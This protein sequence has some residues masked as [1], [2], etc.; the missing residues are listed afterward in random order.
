M[1]VPECAASYLGVLVA[2]AYLD[3]GRHAFPLVGC[4][5][6]LQDLRVMWWVHPRT[7]LPTLLMPACMEG[8]C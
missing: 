4:L 1:V 3:P 5:Q 6:V 8:G 7:R 2:M